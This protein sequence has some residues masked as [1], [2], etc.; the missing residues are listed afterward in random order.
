MRVRKMRVGLN[1]ALTGSLTVDCRTD[2]MT[3]VGSKFYYTEINCDSY[4]IFPILV[5]KSICSKLLYKSW[6]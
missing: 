6:K 4:Q 2:P 3:V 1:L 5:K